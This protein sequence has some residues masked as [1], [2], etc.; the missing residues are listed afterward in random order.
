MPTAC[1]PRRAS[2]SSSPHTGPRLGSASAARAAFAAAAAMVMGLARTAARYRALLARPWR[3]EVSRAGGW[4]FAAQLL[5]PSRLPVLGGG[6][7]GGS[8]GAGQRSSFAAVGLRSRRQRPESQAE[9][10]GAGAAAAAAAQGAGT[11]SELEREGGPG[12]GRGSVR[13]GARGPPP[14]SG[15]HC[16]ARCPGVM[17]AELGTPAPLLPPQLKD[18]EL[19]WGRGAHTDLSSASPEGAT[20]A[21]EVSVWRAGVEGGGKLDQWEVTRGRCGCLD[22]FLVF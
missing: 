8:R 16:L 12:Q 4:V 5:S 2:G 15:W 22:L 3:W 11:G 6:R 10:A 13:V 7:V 14:W 17:L 1:S 20:W 21:A 18:A 19:G 9:P